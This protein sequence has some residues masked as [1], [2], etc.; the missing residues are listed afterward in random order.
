MDL[1]PQQLAQRQ[2]G[3]LQRFT[4]RRA[5]VTVAAGGIGAATS[6]RLVSAVPAPTTMAS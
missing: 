2:S 1:S 3:L 5:L 6:H 4:G